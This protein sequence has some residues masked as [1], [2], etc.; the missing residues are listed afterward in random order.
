MAEGVVVLGTIVAAA[1][2]MTLVAA[3][4][5]GTVKKRLRPLPTRREPLVWVTD[6]KG[7]VARKQTL[8]L[9]ELGS[10]VVT[11]LLPLARTLTLRTPLAS[12]AT[13]MAIS[14]LDALLSDV[15]GVESLVIFLKSARLLCL[16]SVCLL[17]V[18]S[19]LLV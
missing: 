16:G 5:S 2:A 18:V 11:N 12:T 7:C 17:C 4:W 6:G 19:N 3:R 9:V 14:Q 13:P 10:P 15:K 1:M 8:L